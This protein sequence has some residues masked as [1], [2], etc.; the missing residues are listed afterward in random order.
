M[1]V[2]A[3]GLSGAGGI[4]GFPAISERADALARCIDSMLG[5]TGS[6]RAVEGALDALL[7]E[8]ARE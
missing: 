1:R 3:H 6:A 2:I 8:I 7:H 5:G 4:F